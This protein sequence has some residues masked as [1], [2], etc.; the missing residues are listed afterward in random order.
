MRCLRPFGAVAL[1][2]SDGGLLFLGC[3]KVAMRAA[4]WYPTRA[5]AGAQLS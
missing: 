5:E 3:H 1:D 4:S 2:C